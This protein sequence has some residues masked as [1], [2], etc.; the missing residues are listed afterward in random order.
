M[1]QAFCIA[2]QKG[3]VG[4]TTTAISLAD[5]FAK[6]GGRTLLVD[7]DP[8]CNATCG[9]DAALANAHPLVVGTPLADSVVRT[10]TENLD[11]LPGSR[12]FAD[13]EVL[14]RTDQRQNQRM[15]DQLSRELNGYDFVLFDCPPSLGSLTQIALSVSTAIWIPIQCEFFAM[16]GFTQMVEATTQ[17]KLELGG[18]LLT[19]YDASLELTFEVESEVRDFCGEIVFN[20]VI[21]RDVAFSEAASRGWSILDYAPRSHGARAYTELC[22]EVLERG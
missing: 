1:V 20:T 17:E 16:Q 6:A 11:L 21:P 18:V 15:R 7:L 9:L 5:A 3:G 4:K 22:M 8:Q 13:V 14:T 2:N 10:R 12:K 19:M